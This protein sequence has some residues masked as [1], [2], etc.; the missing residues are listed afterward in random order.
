MSQ[1]KSVHIKVDH[2]KCEGCAT[3]IIREIRR[4]KGVSSVT[5]DIERQEVI[6][7]IAEVADLKLIKKKLKKLGYPERGTTEGLEKLAINAISYASCAFGKIGKS[8][9]T[10]GT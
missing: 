2:L 1:T 9:S 7:V 10:L 5:V 3:T 4:I 8:E 6:V